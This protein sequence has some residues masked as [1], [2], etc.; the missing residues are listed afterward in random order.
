MSDYRS[1]K[2]KKVRYHFSL[3]FFAAVLIFGFMFFRYM[4]TTTLEEVLS[5]DRDITMPAL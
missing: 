4:K 2:K 5:E 3:V 1:G